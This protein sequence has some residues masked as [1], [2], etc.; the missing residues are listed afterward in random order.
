M[1]CPLLPPKKIALDVKKDWWSHQSSNLWLLSFSLC[2]CDDGSIVTFMKD[3][4]LWWEGWGSFPKSGPRLGRDPF[5]GC[6]HPRV[7][8]H[9][10]KLVILKVI[11]ILD[12]ALVFGVLAH[13]RFWAVHKVHQSITPQ[14]QGRTTPKWSL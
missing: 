11:F 1:Q 7:L 12:M 3:N 13:L 4:T 9:V 2:R 5:W 6:P 10:I 8:S 14:N